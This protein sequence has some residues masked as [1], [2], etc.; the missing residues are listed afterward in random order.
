M[1]R[2]L[3]S[4]A[5]LSGCVVLA[6]C[7]TQPTGDPTIGSIESSLVTNCDYLDPGGPKAPVP[8]ITFAKELMITDVSV[9]DDPCRSTNMPVG[10]C[11][12]GT[13]G[14]WTFQHLMT[15]MAG[16][17]PVNQ[18]VR[19]W[20]HTFEIPI[21]VNGFPYGPRMPGFRA[22]FLDPWLANSPGCF[23]GQPIV[24]PGACMTLNLAD[25]PFRLLAISNRIDLSGCVGA[26][27]GGGYDSG[28]GQGRFTFGFLGGGKAAGPPLQGTVIFEYEYPSFQNAFGWAATWHV[29]SGLVLPSAVFNT[30]LQAITQSFVLTGSEPGKPNNGSAIGQVRTN[31]ISFAAPW[32]LR[33]FTL[34]NIGFGFN[35]M[36]L[37][38]DTTKMSPDDGL[39]L[40][41][42]T[43]DLDPW[44]V[45]NAPLMPVLNH[46]VP[47]SFFPAPPPA[48]P[49]P[50]LPP[51]LPV[52]GGNACLGG[53]SNA[54]FLWDHSI[55]G[56]LTRNERH[57]FGFT[58]CNGCHSVETNVAFTHINPRPFGF[59]AGLSGFLAV[60]DA[61]GG[62]GT[63]AVS[64]P[65]PDPL[66]PPIVFQYNEP[67]RRKCEVAR[68]LWM[69]GVDPCPYTKQ[70]GL[71]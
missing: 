45:N 10:P 66:G 18:F 37:L 33:E 48:G 63:P 38:N 71:H 20:L 11:A 2:T 35:N 32:Q 15:N 21:N 67:W 47:L 43:G 51:G 60:S 4:W 46:T 19:E 9:V 6:A 30:T 5:L 23:P 16:G 58:T 59:P 7:V 70:H 29:L 57:L 25:A 69:G 44:L 52:G 53:A 49:G 8:V 42:G 27:P 36:R 12:P 64:F 1:R 14:V 41:G 68:L 39:N 22:A 17:T 55:P 34:Q 26:P 28:P 40:G 24:G 54:P 56:T 13:V 3:Y 61:G 50:L 31:E 65:V 62:A